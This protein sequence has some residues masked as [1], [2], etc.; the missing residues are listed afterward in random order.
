M[1]IQALSPT[2]AA[3]YTG[4][5]ELVDACNIEMAARRAQLL[6]DLSIYQSK[7]HDLNE[8]DPLD[9]TGL[10]EMYATHVCQTEKLLSEF[11]RA[12]A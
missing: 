3:P 11:D 8:I 2:P 12:A 5:T 7:L 9:F 6:D 4:L 10:Q 1:Q